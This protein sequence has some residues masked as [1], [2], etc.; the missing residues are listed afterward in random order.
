MPRQAHSKRWL[1]VVAPFSMPVS[2]KR[3]LLYLSCARRGKK[4]SVN[5]H[6]YRNTQYHCTLLWNAVHILRHCTSSQRTW[7]SSHP[8]FPPAMFITTWI[9][10]VTNPLLQSKQRCSRQ[11]L[12][13]SCQKRRKEA[14]NVK[15]GQAVKYV[16]WSLYLW[17]W[18]CMHS[19]MCMHAHTC[20]LGIMPEGW[21]WSWSTD[22]LL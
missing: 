20:A 5:V 15:E 14:S 2:H 12:H 17:M 21:S 6:K 18:V 16:K 9:L 4:K 11:W 19:N 13:F 7:A 22:I 1:G 3:S 10:I 8:F